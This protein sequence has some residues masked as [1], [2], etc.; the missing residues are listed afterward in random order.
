MKLR[1]ITP[2]VH[3]IIDY[4]AALLLIVSPFILKLGESNIIAKWLSVATGIAVI[5]V[6]IN[7]KYKYGWLNVIPFDG[8]LAIDL[9]AATTFSI[10]PIVFGFTGI[11]FQYYIVNAVIVYLVVSLSK[12]YQPLKK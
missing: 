4:F 10:A 11:D 8:H 3:G 9:L 7:T 5:L 6:S 1:I 12:N 2:E